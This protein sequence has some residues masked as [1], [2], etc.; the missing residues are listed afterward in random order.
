MVT[1]ITTPEVNGMEKP[2]GLTGGKTG[3][4]FSV[5]VYHLALSLF[6]RT[7]TIDTTL[8]TSY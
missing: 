1:G 8:P 5:T 6:W 7:P 4:P 2:D 3:V